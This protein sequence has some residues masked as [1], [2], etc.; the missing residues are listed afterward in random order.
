MY[1]RK[2][3]KELSNDSNFCPNC[4]AK[5]TETNSENID[6]IKKTLGKHRKLIYAYVLWIIMHLSLLIN[7][8]SYSRGYRD[9]H[10]GFYP[11]D[12]SL[13][14]LFKYFMG[15]QHWGFTYDFSLLDKY[16]V[17]DFSEF[18]AYIVVLPSILILIAQ[19][20]IS[21][22]PYIKK[23]FIPYT[24]D[25]CSNIKNKYYK[26][27]LSKKQIRQRKNE[28]GQCENIT[29]P[30]IKTTTD[31]QDKIEFC[32]NKK[33]DEEI[34]E[35]NNE[36]QF[37]SLPRRLFG[38]LLDKTII[39]ILFV[40]GSLAISPFGAPKKL[41]NYIGLLE[42]SPFEYEYID[43]VRMSN[44]GD[45]NPLISNYYQARERMVTEPPHLGSTKEL[46]LNITLSFIILNL[47]Y[48]ILFEILLSASPGKYMVGGTLLNGKRKRID[49]AS[50]LMRGLVGAA[51]MLLSVYGL[52][53]FLGIN[54]ISVMI[55]FFVAMDI[56]LFFTKKSLLDIISE[57][58]YAKK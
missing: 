42:T 9:S 54:Y 24:K 56:S 36:V 1:C 47:I 46:D 29:N 15:K 27:K 33:N 11:W 35:C 12:C 41:G 44:Y 3:G 26:W 8:L 19:L 23:Y 51:L 20:V 52:H 18:F 45:F 58:F 16:N 50:V 7:S 2:C 4:G 28:Q 5:Q 25:F 57:T 13:N 31:L 53:F 38:S 17:Y 22:K 43:R 34:E 30:T 49:I 32:V 37:L 10:Y 21:I 14:S 39:I 48:Y 55:V 6:Y 40:V